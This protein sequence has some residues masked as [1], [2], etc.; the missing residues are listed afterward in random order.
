MNNEIDSES[1]PDQP[2]RREG[3]EAIPVHDDLVL[4]DWVARNG[5]SLNE[6]ARKIWELADGSR[7]VTA[8]AEEIAGEIGISDE[9]ALEE[10]EKD[11][12]TTLISFQRNNLLK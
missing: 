12:I 7:T 3:I 10:L 11:L 5:I 8:M 6:T 1:L 9:E 2:E 4:Y